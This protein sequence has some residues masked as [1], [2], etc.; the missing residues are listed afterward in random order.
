VPVHPY[1]TSSSHPM[2]RLWRNSSKISFGLSNSLIF[3]GKW[4]DSCAGVGLGGRVV[5]ALCVCVCVC[6]CVHALNYVF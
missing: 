4:V 1:H 3:S 6:V 5:D 2:L